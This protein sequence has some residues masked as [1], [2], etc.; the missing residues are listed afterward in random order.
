MKETIA[1]AEDAQIDYVALV[2]PDS[3]QPVGQVSSPTLA[4]LAVHIE[5]TRLID[6][7]ILEP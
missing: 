2:D 1:K 6:N 7:C 4:V 3:L 5:N